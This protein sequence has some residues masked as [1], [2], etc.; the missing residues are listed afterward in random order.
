MRNA[1][2]S[3]GWFVRPRRNAQGGQALIYGL[4]VLIGGLAALFFL[5]N[6]GQLVRE[7]SKLVNTT[8]AVAYSAGVMHARALNF[9]A[10][11]NRAMVANTVAIAQLVSLSSWIEYANNLSQYGGTS[12]NNPKFMLFWPSYWAASFSGPY[13]QQSLNDSDSLH[14]L[15]DASDTIIRQALLR[16][17]QVVYGGLLLARKQVMD[18]VAQANY[19]NDGVVVVDTIPLTATEF[20][21]FVAPYSDNDRIRFAEVAKISANKDSFLPS[22]SWALP[23]LWGDCNGWKI[24]WFDRRGGTELL[25]FDEWKAMDTLSEKR[26]VPANKADIFCSALVENSAG[27]GS[28]DAADAS[29]RDS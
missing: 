12:A 8:D 11:A 9:D 18:E 10:Y 26:W 20:T 23:A 24:D 25:G 14:S 7:K 19:R 29:D 22:R 28:V 13:L 21:D 17:Q 1:D 15:S 27:W 16:S 3:T 4:F 2:S 5:F 6:T